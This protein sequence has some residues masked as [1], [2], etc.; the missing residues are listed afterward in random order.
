MRDPSALNCDIIAQAVF[1]GPQRLGVRVFARN[2]GWNKPYIS[3]RIG[4]LLI[5]IE[6]AHALNDIT[7]A[8]REANRAADRAFPK[9]PYK[10]RLSRPASK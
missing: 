4:K 5:N 6:D 1:T 7:Y 2:E 9:P 3:L 8:I 10:P